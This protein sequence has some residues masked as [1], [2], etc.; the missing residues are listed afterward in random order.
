MNLSLQ[1]NRGLSIATFGDLEETERSLRSGTDGVPESIVNLCVNL[2]RTR[3]SMEATTWRAFVKMARDHPVAALLYQDPLTRRAA[4]QP[5]GYQGDAELIDLIYTKNPASIGVTEPTELGGTIFEHLIECGA[6]AAVRHRRQFLAGRI[7]ETASL[8]GP[9]EVLSVACGHMREIGDVL[10]SEPRHLG[11]VVGLDQDAQSLAIV[12]AELGTFGIKTV[13]GSAAH[14][15]VGPLTDE[16][17]DFIYSAGLF[18]YLDDRVCKKLTA[19]MF[20]MLKPGGRLVIANYLVGTPDVG[21]MEAYMDWW[22][23][24]RTQ[25]QIEAFVSTVPEGLIAGRSFS[26]DPFGQVGYLEVDRACSA[27]V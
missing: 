20:N 16:R 21:Y 17:F 7:G 4:Q 19:G 5:R 8:K 24:Y 25:E 23:T 6:P 13:E 12:A 10:H 14:V 9:L 11:R 18:D 22:L 1:G 3:A 15:L 2:N 27:S 26:T